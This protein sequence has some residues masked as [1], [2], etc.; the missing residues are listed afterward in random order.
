MKFSTLLYIFGHE[1]ILAV[2]CLG[3]FLPIFIQAYLR[4]IE[5]LVIDHHNREYCCK[6]SH[7]FFGFPV[8]IE[9]VFILHC[10]LLSVQ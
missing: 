3:F 2:K 4:D 7:L 6:V 1:N 8:H 5:G 10:S 9:V